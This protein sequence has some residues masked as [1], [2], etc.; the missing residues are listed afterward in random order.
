MTYFAAMLL[1]LA[2]WCYHT[3][4]VYKAQRAARRQERQEARR[5]LLW[6]KEHR[7]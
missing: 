2:A 3:S 7:I 6:A 4:P 5:D 1:L